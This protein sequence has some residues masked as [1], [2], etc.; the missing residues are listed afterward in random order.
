MFSLTLLRLRSKNETDKDATRENSACLILTPNLPIKSY[1]ELFSTTQEVSSFLF[2]VTQTK[3]LEIILE[4][5]FLSH[6]LHEFIRK[7]NQFGS[8]N[9]SRIPNFSPLMLLCCCS[10]LHLSHPDLYHCNQKGLPDV[11]L[12]DLVEVFQLEQFHSEQECLRLYNSL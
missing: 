5:P 4:S 6:K 9:I 2:L 10:E 12:Y 7:C 11:T 8:Q 1:L 3:I